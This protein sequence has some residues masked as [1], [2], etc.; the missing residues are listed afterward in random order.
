M[1]GKA[2][3]KRKIGKAILIGMGFFLTIILTFTTTLAWFYDSDWA[4]KHITMAGT[5]GIE[6]QAEDADDNI[7][8]TSGA[9]NLYFHIE[10]EK[11]YPGQAVDVSASVYNNGGKS[12]VKGSDC[13][14]RAHFAVYTDI[15]KLPVESDYGTTAGTGKTSNAYKKAVAQF[16]EANGI[17]AGEATESQLT[18]AGIL[19]TDY[20]IADGQTKPAAYIRDLAAAEEESDM[21][22]E[23]MYVFLNSLIDKQN[24]LLNSDDP[25]T[26]TD[27]YWVYYQHEGAMPLSSTGTETTDVEYYIDGT[28]VKDATHDKDNTGA[29][30]VTSVTEVKDKGY[31]YLCENSL[32]KLKKLTRGTSAV[33]LWNNTFII[34]WQLTNNS[35]G[36]TMF[37]AVTFQAIQT[38][39]PQIK[40]SSGS[41]TGVILGDADNQMPE[42][43]CL[44]NTPAVQTVFN[45]CNFEKID[46]K[47]NIN[48]T[49]VDFGN[50]NYDMVN[51][52]ASGQTAES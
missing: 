6:I 27:Y 35:A 11:A 2:K 49:I 28:K 9:G 47:L 7:I 20:E 5:V 15:G 38:F 18:A 33:F 26:K 22:A 41:S 30:T 36:K 12:G 3:E 25:N 40:L 42:D 43:E 52:L 50:G 8:K 19:A 14:V 39:I 23:A 31:F 29:E 13:Y 37:V 24:A 32:G 46:T 51:K 1:K 45:S 10:G 16:E 48:G 44:Y 21:N 34:P 4:S 17:A